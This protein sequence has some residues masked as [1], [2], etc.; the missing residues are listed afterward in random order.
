MKKIKAL[1]LALVMLVGISA[2]PIQAKAACG[3]WFVLCADGRYAWGDVCG[4]SHADNIAAVIDF[5]NDFC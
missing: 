4:S 2:L 5:A 1:V 3:D